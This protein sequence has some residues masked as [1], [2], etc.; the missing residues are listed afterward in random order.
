MSGKQELEPST[1][2]KAHHPPRT[3][4][5]LPSNDLE[6]LSDACESP[7]DRRIDADQTVA[8]PHRSE[9]FQSALDSW[10]IL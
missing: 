3:N 2:G 5:H 9:S 8:S 6:I 10:A 7:D 1:S 4:S